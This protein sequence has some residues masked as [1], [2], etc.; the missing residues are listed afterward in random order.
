MGWGETRELRRLRKASRP[1][2]SAYEIYLSSGER[3]LV[4][5]VKP[6]IRITYWF[7]EFCELLP[8]GCCERS[9]SQTGKSRTS[10]ECDYM[11]HEFCEFLE[12]SEFL[13]LVDL[14]GLEIRARRLK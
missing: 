6:M 12:V 3:Q 7:G 11:I 9:P 2:H 10:Y 14:W 4:K 1:L 5:R 13:K 8:H